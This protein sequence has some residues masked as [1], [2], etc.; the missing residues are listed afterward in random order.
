[1]NNAEMNLR[2]RAGARRTPV[3]QVWVGAVPRV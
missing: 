2:P 3:R 1:M